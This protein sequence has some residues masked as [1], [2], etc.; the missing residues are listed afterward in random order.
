MSKAPLKTDLRP[1]LQSNL[2]NKAYLPPLATVRLTFEKVHLPI[3]QSIHQLIHDR[4]RVTAFGGGR[5]M[6]TQMAFEGDLTSLLQ[7]ALDRLD[8][9]EHV[10]AIG[11][12]FLQG[13]QNAFQVPFRDGESVRDHLARSFR[14]AQ[15]IPRRVQGM[16]MRFLPVHF[17]SA[18]CALYPSSSMARIRVPGFVFPSTR[19]CPVSRLTATFSTPAT[20]WRVLG[21]DRTQGSPARPGI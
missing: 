11:I 21:T 14:H 13:V 7:R 10:Y 17:E 20:A 9:A 16:H 19:A 3:A 15:A 1:C 6:R 8:L 5:H 4:F 12:V 2:G 18:T